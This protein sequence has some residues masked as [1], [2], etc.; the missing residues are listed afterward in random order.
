MAT[1]RNPLGP[2]GETV[3]ANVARLRDELR[4]TYPELSRRLEDL[5]RP[6]PVLGLSRIEKGER[7]VDADDLVA[8]ALA[9]GV[10]PITLLMP[11]TEGEDDPVEATGT[12][13]G[14][15][16]FWEYLGANDIPGTDE[17]KYLFV[18]RSRPKWATDI[19]ITA[20]FKV[21]RIA[22]FTLKAPNGDD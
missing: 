19:S 6:I 13:M 18:S 15:F 14:A 8:L 12:K 11:A 9:L 2:T 10:S 4:L 22:S 7:R 17:E 16:S 20:N 21:R 1:K 5:G 3:R